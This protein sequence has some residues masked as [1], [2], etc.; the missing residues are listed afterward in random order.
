LIG[1]HR[2]VFAIEPIL[3]EPKF[4]LP[5]SRAPHEFPESSDAFVVID[6]TPHKAENDSHF[7]NGWSESE[8]TGFQY[9]D[10]FSKTM[11]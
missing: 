1:K 9:Y 2:H 10:P 8:N 3:E 6:A 4:I 5:G 7:Q 11:K